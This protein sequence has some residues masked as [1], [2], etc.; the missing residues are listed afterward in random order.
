MSLPTTHY[1]LP[2]ILVITGVFIQYK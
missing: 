2:E 1:P